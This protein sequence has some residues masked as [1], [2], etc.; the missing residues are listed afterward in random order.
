MDINHINIVTRRNSL[1]TRAVC[2]AFLLFRDTNLNTLG[3]PLRMC[4]NFIFKMAG[5]EDF[6]CGDDLD[7][8][9]SVI[10]ED[11]LKKMEILKKIWQSLL[12]VS[13]KILLRLE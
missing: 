1:E 6:L 10:E 9:Y 13:K 7:A 11:L 5:R 3:W 2:L 4:T 12:V 8:V